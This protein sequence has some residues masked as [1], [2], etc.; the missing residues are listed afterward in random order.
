MTIRADAPLWDE[1]DA[2]LVA[3]PEVDDFWKMQAEGLGIDAARLEAWWK[4]SRT[5]QPRPRRLPGLKV[6]GG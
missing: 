4:A 6:R 1:L 2:E 5:H 3:E